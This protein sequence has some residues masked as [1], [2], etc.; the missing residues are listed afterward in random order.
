MT[1]YLRTILP[2]AALAVATVCFTPVAH[3]ADEPKTKSMLSATDKT[4]VKKAY[5]GG[6][7]EVANGKVAQE[8]A[9]DEA[10]KKVADQ[11]VTDHSKANDE[12]KKIA[13]EEKLDLSGVSAKAMAI[14]GDNFDKQYLMMLQ[15]EH[16]KDIAMFEKE[17][18]DAKP[19]ED[20]DV[21]SFAKNTL[22][23]L[24]EHLAMINDAL[25]KVK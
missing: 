3:A 5:K 16:E 12:L 1:K 23:T 8:K 4:F 7:S 10:T 13:D 18:N 2:A 14:S 19:G 24:K 6:L 20:R 9:K 15:K 22:P 11:M 17:A 21:P 25:A